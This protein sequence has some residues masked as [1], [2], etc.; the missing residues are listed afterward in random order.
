MAP[1]HTE[2]RAWSRADDRGQGWR[3]EVDAKVAITPLAAAPTPITAPRRTKRFDVR[4]VEKLRSVIKP[5]DLSPASL[6]WAPLWGFAR[7]AAA[8]SGP[9][10]ACHRYAA[11]G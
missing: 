3:A 7:S 1:V 9:A 4:R 10:S 6:R 8:N 2:H 5:G 11:F